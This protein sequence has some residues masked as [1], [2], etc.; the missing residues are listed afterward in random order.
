M[1]ANVRGGGD[2]K[3]S[4]QYMFRH[5]LKVACVYLIKLCSGV[6]RIIFIVDIYDDDYGCIGVYQATNFK[7][8]IHTFL[9]PL[10][11]CRSCCCLV[12]IST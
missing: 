6:D 10:R 5:L 11:Y 1:C 2:G 7:R 12:A 4:V 9:H 3:Q 8:S